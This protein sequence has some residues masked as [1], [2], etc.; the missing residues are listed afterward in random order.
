MKKRSF[1]RLLAC[2]FALFLLVFSFS[3]CNEKI[4]AEY[5]QSLVHD[6]AYNPDVAFSSNPYTYIEAKREL[7]DEILSA[8]DDVLKAFLPVLRSGEAGLDAYIMAAAC[9][10]ISGVGKDG[11]LASAPQWLDLYENREVYVPKVSELDGYSEKKLEEALLGISES[12]VHDIWGEPDG[13]LSGLWGDI[14]KIDGMDKY[15]IVY[16]D[17]NGYVMGVNI[18][19]AE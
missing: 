19:E 4:S 11:G 17:S 3:A 16:Y 2:F 5:L 10:E 14:Y 15:A 6:I 18:N 8:G 7:Y 9:A 12:N 1:L 13:H